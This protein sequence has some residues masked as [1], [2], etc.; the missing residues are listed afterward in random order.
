[1]K[2]HVTSKKFGC[3]TWFLIL[4]D[5]FWHEECHYFAYYTY[6]MAS[7]SS[8]LADKVPQIA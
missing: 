3:V 1:M 2:L 8:N 7:A 6:Q 5:L 4:F